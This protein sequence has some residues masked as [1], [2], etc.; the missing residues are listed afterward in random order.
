LSND[1]RFVY[2]GW[3]LV[4]ELNASS[5]QPNATFV[6][7]L[8]LSGSMQGAGGVGGLLFTTVNSEL[9]TVNYAPAYDGNGN[10]VALIDLA[11]GSLSAEY[12][13]SPFGEVIKA[14]GSSATANPFRFST[15][16]TD[17][18]TGLLY[19]GNRYYSPSAGRWLSR[20]PIEEDGGVNLYGF[21]SNDPISNTD[22]I[23]LVETQ[24]IFTPESPGKVPVH[25]VDL[26]GPIDLANRIIGGKTKVAPLVECHCD[27]CKVKCMM[28][29]VFVIELNAR[30]KKRGGMPFWLKNYGHEQQHV[31]SNMAEFTKLAQELSSE[32]EASWYTSCENRAEELQEN[33]YNKIA[34]IRR[35]EANHLNPGSPA[36][37][38]PVDPAEPPPP[39]WY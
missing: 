8:D 13:F 33:Y 4:A 17:A 7:G 1:T 19:Y 18:E 10:I 30:Y 14:S 16:Y 22:S 36:A 21:V 12:E 35:E 31:R 3:S 39:G 26:G 5:L 2:D 34:D 9:G 11:D 23:G 29:F 25:W 24:L 20:D 15:K 37:G 6:W 28:R 27:G 32:A 38:T